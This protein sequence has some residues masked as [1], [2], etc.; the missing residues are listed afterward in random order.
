MV[1]VIYFKPGDEKIYIER[2]E[3]LEWSAQSGL[4]G[5]GAANLGA[6]LV[7]YGPDNKVLGEFVREVVAGYELRPD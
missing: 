6:C 4:P 1:A 7:V 2:A 3:R 5:G